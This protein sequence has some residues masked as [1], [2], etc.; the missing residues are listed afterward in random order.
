MPLSAGEAAEQCAFC[1]W[2]EDPI[3][4][5]HWRASYPQL[6]LWLVAPF[7]PLMHKLVSVLKDS[8]HPRV[9]DFSLVLSFPP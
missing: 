6:Q 2:F 8:L 4:C 7:P 9:A 5:L 3:D 1:W